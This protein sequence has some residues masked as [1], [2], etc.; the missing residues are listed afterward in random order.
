MLFT[1]SS[2]L[3]SSNLSF[4]N[5]SSIPFSN[6]SSSG[7][8]FSSLFSSS[9]YSFNP[10]YFDTFSSSS[11]LSSIGSSDSN[12]SFFFYLSL[13]P[14]IHLLSIYIRGFIVLTKNGHRLLSLFL[15]FIYSAATF[16]SIF[17]F[18]RI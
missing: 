9:L 14:S 7:P 11:D 17:S 6:Q 12:S 18:L 15:I 1:P 8:S 10:V 3:L 5:L 4:F 16:T 13:D 2:T